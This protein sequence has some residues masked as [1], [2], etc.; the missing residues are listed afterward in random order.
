MIN[1]VISLLYWKFLILPIRNSEDFIRE[2]T[3]FLEQLCFLLYYIWCFREFRRIWKIFLDLLSNDFDG[4]DIVVILWEG[5]M[6]NFCLITVCR[7]FFFFFLEVKSMKTV[8][9]FIYS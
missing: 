7:N 6:G 3:I 1:F 8:D 9:P 5:L 2:M 4:F